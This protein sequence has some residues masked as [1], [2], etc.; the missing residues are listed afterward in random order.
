MEIIEWRFLLI[1]NFTIVF[2]KLST[3]DSTLSRGW[4]EYKQ[5]LKGRNIDF[6]LIYSHFSPVQYSAHYPIWDA[7]EHITFNSLDSSQESW[8]LSP[9]SSV[10]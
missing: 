7:N 2:I 1:T 9:L 4:G 6:I 5:K 3:I 10:M 8:R